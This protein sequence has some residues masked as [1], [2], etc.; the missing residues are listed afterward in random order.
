M[1]TSCLWQ[2]ATMHATHPSGGTGF[3]LIGPN[4]WVHELT[5]IDRERLLP[6]IALRSA[7]VTVAITVFAV[8]SG[9]LRDAIPLALGGFFAA[10]AD[11]G[12]HVGQ[13]W[14]TMLWTTMW[15][16]LATAIGGLVAGNAAV[17]IV[18]AAVVAFACG[19]AASLG[20]RG[21]IIGVLTL[22]IFNAFSV[23]VATTADVLRNAGMVAIGALIQTLATVVF[24]L[25]TRPRHMLRRDPRPSVAARLREHWA[26]RDLFRLH[27][28]RLTAAIVIGVVIEQRDLHPHANWIPIVI[29]WVTL[30]DRHGTVTKVAARITGTLLGAVAMWFVGTVLDLHGY[31]VAAV[32]AMG[33][34]I[35]VW[36]LR[37]NYSLAVIGITIFMLGLFDLL[38]QPIQMLIRNRILDTIVAGVIVL[39]VGLV[40]TALFPARV[41]TE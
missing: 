34:F 20:P 8:A 12:E 41:P 31:E 32:I 24:T 37:A 2:A 26:R 9:S 28:M 25:L 22:V 5:R 30:P 16:T 14:R 27:A 39:A 7:V 38:G 29:A 6:G 17:L 11:T 13:R 23:P 33:A 40:G 3:S 4:G 21:A 18:C 1:G 10:V 15:L 19:Y 36:L 35:S